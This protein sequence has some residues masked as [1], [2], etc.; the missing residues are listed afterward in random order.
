MSP[1]NAPIA[2]PAV[3]RVMRASQS[4]VTGSVMDELFAA[5]E[6]ACGPHRVDGLHGA[7]LYSSGWFVLWLEGEAA[8]VDAVLKRSSRHA[9]H[10]DPRIIHRSIGPATLTEALTLASTQGPEAA[11]DFARRIGSVANPARALEPHEIWRLLSEP[12]TLVDPASAQPVRRHIA[13]VASDDNHSIDIVRKLAERFRRPMVYQRFAGA[14]LHTRDVGAAYVDIPV[15][16]QSTRVQVLSR[17]AL[18]LRMVRESMRGVHSLALLL[19]VRPGSAI[20]LA[21]SVAGFVDAASPQAEID[22]VGE[23]PHV[24]KTVGDYLSERLRTATAK[25]LP[26]PEAGLM[27]YLVGARE[28]PPGSLAPA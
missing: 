27:D 5:R 25:I 22:L 8:K 4:R 21:A 16:G 11:G 28:A 23:C 14:E 13:L 3:T 24:A 2:S 7:L 26:I 19:G 6:R 12:C 18:G 10:R 1:A 15:D 9:C 17:A 20:D